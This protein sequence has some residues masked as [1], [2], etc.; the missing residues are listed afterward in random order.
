MGF[1]F[2]GQ[3]TTRRTRT[4][5]YMEIPTI[6]EIIHK[7]EEHDKRMRED[8]EYRKLMKSMRYMDYIEPLIKHP[9]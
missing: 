2:G 1:S 5:T 3:P 9:K 7:L 8:K 4:N 6:Q